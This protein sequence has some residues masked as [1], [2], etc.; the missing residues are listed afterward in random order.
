M[1]AALQ[2]LGGGQAAAKAAGADAR[3]E[4]PS[5]DGAF[6]RLMQAE[7]TAAAKPAARPSPADAAGAAKA[8]MRGDAA[9]S[10][11]DAAA[12]PDDENAPG[13]DW[14]PL[15]LGIFPTLVLA[16]NAVDTAA[17]ASGGGPA[18]A[19]LA[20]AVPLPSAATAVAAQMDPRQALLQASALPQ[21]ASAAASAGPAPALAANAPVANAQTQAQPSA[22]AGQAPVPA[23]ALPLA[24]PG[25]AFDL[26]RE[27]G[28]AI[29]RQGDT[30]ALAP[31]ANT[32]Q[33]P[34][35]GSSFGLARTAVVNAME[36]PTADLHGDGFDEAVGSRLTW[37]AEQKIGHAHIR[38]NPQELGPVEIRM[39]LDGERVHAD[40]SSPQAEVRQALE[41]SLPRLRDM[42]AQHGFQLAQADVGHHGQHGQPGRN[43]RTAE[44]ESRAG[45]STVEPSAGTTLRVAAR[46]LLDAYA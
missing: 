17:V 6:A 25:I 2:A 43:D 9:S 27:A 16:S 37:M 40:F 26:P 12:E 15:G 39:R 5:P 24:A 21:D 44:G 29:R 3:D 10:D 1:A 31:T 35:A 23:S 32:M 8:P 30:D 38:L 45:G 34:A 11:D 28:D 22:A 4:A 14:P 41:N 19:G 46:G 33:S 20:T 7:D 13:L 42:L 18:T 36:A